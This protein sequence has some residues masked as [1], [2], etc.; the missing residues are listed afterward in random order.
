MSLYKILFCIIGVISQPHNEKNEEIKLNFLY[1]QATHIENANKNCDLGYR[2]TFC[3]CPW[4]MWKS[5]I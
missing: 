2:I 5:R 1:L 4:I 3:S